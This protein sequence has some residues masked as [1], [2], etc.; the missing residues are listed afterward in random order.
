MLTEFRV[1][2]FKNFENELVF[3]LDDVKNYEFNSNCIKNDCIKTSLIYGMNGSGKSNLGLAIFDI[4]IHLTDKEKGF[5]S[6]RQYLN[7]DCSK[8]AKFYYKFKFDDSILEYTYEKANIQKLVNEKVVINDD[9]VLSYDYVNHKAF[10]RLKGAETL[11]VDLTEKNISFIKYVGSNTILEDN[12]NNFVFTK[13]IDFVNN[14]LLFS[15]LEK[16]HYQGFETGTESIPHGIIKSGKI[17]DFQ[18]FLKQV[19]IS[20]ELQAKEIDGENVIMC[21][22]G[23]KAV[24]FYS[25]A[26][27]GTSSLALFY[28]WLIKMDK[29]SLVFIDEFDAFYHNS[30]AKAVVKEVLKLN[31]Q[32]IITTHNTSIMNNDLLRPDCYFNLENGKIRSFS[33]ST[34]KELRKAHNLEKMYKAGQFDE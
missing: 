22:F 23:D 21:K 2:G 9:E 32:A 14:M 4:T 1:E 25:I 3:K 11:N 8:N 29:V 19:G 30:L 26:S 31:T 16:N 6:Y 10:V 20:Y 28:Y 27:K 12:K 17:N 5:S 18:K 24:N 7:L 15:S 33:N 13:F 34:N